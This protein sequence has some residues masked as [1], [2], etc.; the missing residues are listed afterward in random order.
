MKM[1]FEQAVVDPRIKFYEVYARW[2]DDGDYSYTQNDEFVE[3]I[4]AIHEPTFEEAESFISYDLA[5]HLYHMRQY[6]SYP[7]TNPYHVVQVAECSTEIAS[8]YGW[9]QGHNY[10]VL[11]TSSK[12]T[13]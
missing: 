12:P 13:S 11:G 3:C 5:R 4:M 1:T 7:I 6:C 9:I 10:D 2:I 8:T